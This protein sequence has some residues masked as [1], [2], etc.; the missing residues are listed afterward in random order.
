MLIFLQAILFSFVILYRSNIWVALIPNPS[1]MIVVIGTFICFFSILL[2]RLYVIKYPAHI[3]FILI[4]SSLIMLAT[5]LIDERGVTQIVGYWLV[6][7]ICVII[8]SLWRKR[9]EM[10]AIKVFVILCSVISLAGIVAWLI[11]NVD[12]IFKGYIDP[13]HV[14]NLA[15]FTQERM[16]RSGNAQV[17][18]V[19][20]VSLNA[21]SFPY[22]LGL[23]LTGSYAYELFGIPF[24][25]ASAI[26][27]EPSSTAFMIIPALVLTFNSI[28]FSKWQRR[29]LLSIQFCFLVISLSLSIA[30]SVLSA[31]I[32][33]KTLGLFPINLSGV[34]LKKM[35]CFAVII[36]VIG[37]LGVYSFNMTPTNEL[38]KNVIASKLFGNDYLSIALS[39]IFNL[40]YFFA[41]TYFFSVSLFCAFIAAKNNNDSLMSFSLIIICFLIVSLKGAFLHL[42]LAPPGFFVLFFLMLKNLRR[43]VLPSH[44]YQSVHIPLKSAINENR[45]GSKI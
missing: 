6:S 23:I 1:L 3:V 20:G 27:H 18:N 41:Y 38:A 13:T 32:L 4:V 12:F 19:F 28:Y 9:Q 30:F 8:V 7:G 43:S 31:F 44:S 14:I 42:V 39:V 36:S 16:V 24:F 22:S 25:R 45:K 15:E 21:Y 11:V 10:Y 33:Y 40:K 35:F 26:F 17:K 37:M 29:A 2:R 5:Q 34:N